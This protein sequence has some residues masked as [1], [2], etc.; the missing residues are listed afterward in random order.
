[1]RVSCSV[2]KSPRRSQE[3]GVLAHGVSP[4]HR[5]H[6][7]TESL[8]APNAST[9]QTHTVVILPCK[10][11]TW[12]QSGSNTPHWSVAAHSAKAFDAFL[13]DA[14]IGANSGGAWR[15]SRPR[16]AEPARAALTRAIA[17]AQSIGRS[18]GCAYHAVTLALKAQR[19]RLQKGVQG[20][21]CFLKPVER[22]LVQFRSPNV[23]VPSEMGRGTEVVKHNAAL[24]WACLQVFL[25]ADNHPR[26]WW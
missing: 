19:P 8:R 21:E 9:S 24:H 5:A 17:P 15:G 2:S 13:T 11:T 18:V 3:R 14:P 20:L 6:A 23:D 25:D 12:L 10:I 22:R 4:P 26:V 7:S 1:V 16:S